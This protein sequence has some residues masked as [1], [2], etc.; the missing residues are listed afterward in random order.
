MEEAPTAD[1]KDITLNLNDAKMKEDNFKLAID[2]YSKDNPFKKV[3]I[4]S[5]VGV[6]GSFSA[7]IIAIGLSG[8]YISGGI[9]FYDTALLVGGY[10]A[11]GAAVGLVVAVPAIL[12]GIGY[13][14]YKI[15]KTKKLKNYMNKMNEESS[16]EEREILSRLTQ[17]CIYYF[18]NYMKGSYESKLKDLVK[19]D[20][21]DIIKKIKG[22][23]K[24]ENNKNNIKYQIIKEIDAMNFYNIILIGNTG[25]G[26]STLINEFLQL[27]NNIAKENDTPD[28][29]KIENWPKKYPVSP[30]DTDVVG[31]RLY[32]TEGIEKTGENEFQKHLNTIINFIHSP[33]SDLKDKIN[34]I[35][36]CIHNNKL[37][38]DEKYIEDIFKLFSGLR[39][40]IIFIFTKAYKTSKKEIKSIKQGLLKFD[41][42][43]ENPDDL[44]FI[45]VIAKD[46]VDEDD[47]E[48]LEKKK[49]LDTL[50][51]E[52]LKLSYNL[53][54]APIMKKISEM[55]NKN[56]EKIIENLSKKLLEQYDD[57]VTKHD[58]LKTFDEKFFDIFIN[59]YGDLDWEHKLFI[60]QKISGWMQILEEIKK[61]ELKK[62][63][64]NYDKKYLMNNIEDFV[65][66]KYD[67]KVKRYKKEKIDFNKDYKEFKEEINDYL[68]TQINSSKDIYGLYSLFDL[69]RDTMLEEI[70]QDLEVDLNKDKIET[71]VEMQK[72]IVPKK[73]EE[74]TQ[75]IINKIK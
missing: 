50:L 58:K 55:F 69:V 38:G 64:K 17:Q 60:R 70:F 20:T 4:G 25:V 43:K 24:K 35:W 61:D 44:H 53:T 3:I 9:L 5:T 48:I 59:L 66:Q 54:M 71:Q 56:S 49:G 21:E 36:Y 42:F 51:E 67:E 26:K 63:Q 75:K 19:K 46:L 14:I 45:E 62:A 23:L 18:K 28:P 1:K 41:F 32:D 22:N 37:D 2:Y 11:I 6:V 52:T 47:G 40:P 12:G 57:I 15:V 30:E 27:K 31:I 10:A 33:E 65:K 13:G 16:M 29:Q 39:I 73:L 34:A 8:A 7:S 74:L 72:T 68:V